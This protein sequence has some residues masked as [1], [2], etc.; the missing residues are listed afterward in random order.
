[1]KTRSGLSPIG[2][3]VGARHVKAVQ[4]ALGAGAPRVVAAA[5]FPRVEPGAALSGREM[6]RA[7]GVLDRTGFVG[8]ACVVAVPRS[9]LLTAELE[10]PPS[11]SEAPREQIA[12]LELA[13]VHRREASGFELG[14]WE[15]PAPAR[16]GPGA[17][18]LGV[19]CPHDA[20]EGLL[21]RVETAGLEVSALDHPG[22][23]LARLA[24]RG[25]VRTR[26][27]L[28]LGWS[29]A[30]VVLVRDGVVLY[31]RVIEGG[32][33]ESLYASLRE[34]TGFEGSVIDELLAGDAW[35]A[36]EGTRR[37]RHVLDRA[38]R[39]VNTHTERVARELSLSLG[40]LD[41]RFPRQGD[42]GAAALPVD[43]VG[44]GAACVGV[45]ER[46][47]RLAP[48][49]MGVLRPADMMGVD[50]GVLRVCA[51]PSLC[52]AAGLAARREEGGA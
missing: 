15:I 2:L 18:A 26:A 25:G 12:R 41:T 48:A 50:E 20:A 36:H 30:V 38:V 31:E 51:S 4:L 45:V 11:G 37:G 35:S 17:H 27:L 10:L 44:G 33:F 3:D 7:A 29:A 5:C 42:D 21:E 9:A 8:R 32:A 28:D 39:C 6:E 24:S 1:M 43:L 52:L 49:G 47:V 14:V 46:L 40:Y 19:A 13:R 22:C 16:A 23:A 34:Q